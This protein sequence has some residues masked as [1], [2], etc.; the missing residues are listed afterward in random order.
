MKIVCIGGGPAGLYFALLM[1]QQDPANQVV[2][3]ERNPAY[4]GRSAGASCSP[5][6]RSAPCAPPIRFRQKPSSPAAAAGTISIF[7]SKA[8]FCAQAVT[9]LSRSAAARC[10]AS[11]RPVVRNSGSTS[12]CETQ[13]ESD[14][15]VARRYDADLV[16]AADGIN[17]A[18]RTRYAE[19]YEPEV[20][21]RHCRFVWL[22]T[23]RIFEAFNFIFVPTEHG[24]F[25]AHAYRF[26]EGISTFIVETTEATWQASGLD[27][28]TQEDGIAFCE[29]LFAPWL[30]GHR[31]S[32]NAAHLRGSAIWIRFP[33][34]ICRTWVHWTKQRHKGSPF[35]FRSC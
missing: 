23:T 19:S 26:E 35:F 6:Q 32:S 5:M 29:R 14:A 4:H 12:I 20:D 3:L 1:K 27:R 13:V 34:V 10:S 8:A 18:V 28:M 24:W 17:S 11:C 22:G 31:L 30:D 9:R 7:I 33:R 15:E 25:Q 21:V 2:V 16:I